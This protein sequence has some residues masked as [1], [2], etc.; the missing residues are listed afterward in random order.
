M[1]VVTSYPLAVALCV[2][3]ML[4]WGSW[5]NTQKA[6]GKSW[7]FELFYWDYVFGVVILAVV[8]AFTLGSSGDAGRSFLADVRLAR[9]GFV[10]SA[11]AGG[12]VFN[13]AN[14]LLV[15][16]IAI[17]GMSVAFPVG[18]G[19][20]L[21]VGVGVNYWNEPAG[22]A[23]LLVAGVLLVS[24]AIV[25]NAVAYRRLPGQDRGVSMKGLLLAV[26]CGVLMGF[27]Y[28]LVART[29]FEDPAN[30]T[31][32]YMSPYTAVFFFSLGILA[33][34]LAFNQFIM[35]KPFVGEP[36]TWA[37]YCKGALW[38]H[39][40]GVLGGVIWCVG[41]TLNIVAS[42][43]ASPAVSYG[44][45][46]GATMVAALWGVFVWREFRDAPPGTS[47]LLGLMF[48]LYLGGLG[49]IILARM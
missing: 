41:M 7:R 33:S 9:F 18:I 32:G 10:L 27:F 6:A 34:N 44:L 17:A 47:R 38:R 12:V 29:M 36:V 40:L 39:G 28:L 35:A 42:M 21:V 14:I 23:A 15:A 49:L 4:C 16:A 31:E 1:F 46:Q 5:A 3:T 45:G 11:L 19:L 24:G 20:A 2:V 22:N 26:A 48:G 43:K 8:S 37:D 30:P 13:L 25:C